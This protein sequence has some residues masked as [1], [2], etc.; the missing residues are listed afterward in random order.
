[1]R[2]NH[3][4]CFRSLKHV[5]THVSYTSQV[6]L[7]RRDAIKSLNDSGIPMLQ[8]LRQAWE[9]TLLGQG[10][11]KEPTRGRRRVTCSPWVI[12][13]LGKISRELLIP[14]RAALRRRFRRAPRS[15][16]PSAK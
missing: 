5:N 9:Y 1:M 2:S 12:S 13:A 16:S 15:A 14:H 10:R 6:D 8:V 11:G 4:D 7:R 3:C